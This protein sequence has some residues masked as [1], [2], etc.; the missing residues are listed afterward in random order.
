MDN[1]NLDTSGIIKIFRH[2]L[3]TLAFRLKRV[4]DGAPESFANFDAGSGVRSPLEILRHMTKLLGFTKHLLNSSETTSLK[5]VDWNSEV[6]RFGS[7]L[8][9]LDLVFQELQAPDN[10][11][12]LQA[13]QGPLADAMTHIGQLAT[14]RRMVGAP[15][16]GISYARATIEAGKF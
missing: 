4:T 14:L 1:D 2:Y 12:L 8:S 9:E 10:E 5:E 3:A 15:L 7:G 13:L 11:K 6:E 16:E